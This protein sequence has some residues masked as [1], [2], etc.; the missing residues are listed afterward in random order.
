[1]SSSEGRGKRAER[2]ERREKRQ[3]RR[4]QTDPKRAPEVPKSGLQRGA[5]PFLHRPALWGDL[6]RL[7]GQREESREK[8]EESRKNKKHVFVWFFR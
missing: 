6:W 1:M 2:E 8:R 4:E 3:E 7:R 5:D